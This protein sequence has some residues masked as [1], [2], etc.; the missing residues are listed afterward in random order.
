MAKVETSSLKALTK[1]RARKNIKTGN[2]SEKII[3]TVIFNSELINHLGNEEKPRIQ[4]AGLKMLATYFEAYVDNLARSN[5]YRFHHIYEWDATGQKGARLFNSNLTEGK[6]PALTYSFKPSAKPS[7]SGYV[8]KNKAFVMENALPLT[9][10]PRD[11]EY[12]RF[13]V[14]GRFV[15]TK[16]VYVSQPGG[17]EVGGAFSEVFNTFMTT[18]GNNALED[19]GFFEKIERGILNETRVN[20]SRVSSGRI[21]GMAAAASASANKIVRG[22]R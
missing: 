18:M 9:I 20:L 7:Q 22:L 8:F 2:I 15:S 19:L 16:S 6:I 4:L 17:T 3:S 13:E 14:D 11:E 12:L 5:P 21:E 1:P 10:K